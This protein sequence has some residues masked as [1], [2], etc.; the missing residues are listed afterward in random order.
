MT[1]IKPESQTPA[2]ETAIT[3]AL[4]EEIK[5]ALEMMQRVR[6]AQAAQAHGQPWV[7]PGNKYEIPEPLVYPVSRSPECVWQIYRPPS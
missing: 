2:A 6:T 1:P 4:A 5:R 7:P 3:P